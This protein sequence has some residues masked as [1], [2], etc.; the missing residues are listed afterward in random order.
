MTNL[1]T[2]EEKFGVISAK[3]KNKTL[4]DSLI[5]DYQKSTKNAVENILNMCKSVKEIDEKYKNKEIND[6]D[7]TYFCAKVNLER[8]SSTYRKFRMIG[9][10]ANRFDEYKDL[11]PSAYTVLFQIATL[12]SDKFEELIQNNQI[13][14]SLSL[15]KLKKLIN[16]TKVKFSNEGGFRVV[17]DKD[18]LSKK[19]ENFL[20][21]ILSDLSNL[22]DV[23]VVMPKKNTHILN[24]YN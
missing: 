14:P 11:L 15:E 8:R 4:M 3:C 23:E 9:E 2:V 21:S 22:S 19:S 12:D 1:I 7:V 16:K 24:I 6:F 17:F 18:S 13:T 5:N 10:H 20:K